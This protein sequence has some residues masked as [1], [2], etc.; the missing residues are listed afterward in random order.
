MKTTLLI[1]A[2][3]FTL[4]SCYVHAEAPTPSFTYAAKVVRVIDG[5]TIKVDI[6]LGF[7]VWVH[8]HSIR[9]LG[10]H[11][12][13]ITGKDKAIGQQETA[14]L[15]AILPAGTDIVLITQ[16]DRSDKYGRYLGR[17][18]KGELDVNAEML[19]LP[20]GGK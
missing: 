16:K 14:A 7:G 10:V 2:C 5:D 18:Y 20:Q 13:E 3:L 8:N 9:L 15:A 12:P 1:L 19:K 6:D 17:I 11:A 4:S